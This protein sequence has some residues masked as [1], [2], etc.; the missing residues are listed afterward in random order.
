MTGAGST[1][2]I[3]G[4]TANGVP[5]STIQAQAEHVGPLLDSAKGT[6]EAAQPVMRSLGA[7]SDALTAAITE[8]QQS[9]AAVLSQTVTLETTGNHML[10]TADQVETKATHDY[11]HP[12]HNPFKRAWQATEPFIVA[13]ARITA[14]LF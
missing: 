11:L 6:V 10:T 5:L 1:G 2:E 7:S 13:G 9:V 4:M 12:S 14:A 3:G 8:N